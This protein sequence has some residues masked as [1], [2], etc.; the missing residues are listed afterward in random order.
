MRGQSGMLA[1]HRLLLLAACMWAA[2][3]VLAPHAQQLVLDEEFAQA[4]QTLAAPLRASLTPQ[5][6]VH[7]V[8]V[9]DPA[10]NAFV[11]SENIIFIHSGLVQ[12]A[13]N[14]AALQGVIAHEL[15]H[16]ASN[17]LLQQE[18]HA[19]Q[20]MLGALAGAALGIGA[21]AAGAPQ[22]ATALMVG[23][24]AGAIQTMLSHTRTQEAEADS[25]AIA[26]LHKAGLSAQGMVD[27]FTTL[28]T[29][30]Q[31][32]YDA[33]PPWLVTHPLPPERLS[34]LTRATQSESA[35]L[36]SGLAKAESSINFPRLQAKVMALTASPGAVLRKY[37]AFD[38]VSRYARALAYTRQGKLDFAESNLAPILKE[39]PTDPFYRELTGQIA[40]QRGDLP[41]AYA[42]YKAL[43]TEFPDHIMFRYQLAE[44][45]RNQD[46]FPDAIAHYQAVTRMWP[47][48]AEP[49]LGLGL[50]YG[51]MGRLAE[52]HL[53][54]AQGFLVA[55]N[56]E[57]AR[58]SLALAQQ[59]LRTTP[60]PDAEQW[61]T[62][63]QTRLDNL[64]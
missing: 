22:A 38:S 4:A 50:C 30:S 53:A 19:K 49:W 20:A 57:A 10:I 33:P 63:L 58:Q 8:L 9:N 6:R 35:Q 11:T 40:L 14:A 16:I 15:A 34:S 18:V 48:W 45:L 60:N 62:A 12:K 32:S 61:A 13:K 23:G 25:R 28:R 2:A 36:T 55:P 1:K 5:T 7:Y 24:Q 27:M 52:S 64:K 26:A 59:Y 43:A 42:I 3:P 54:R 21:A 47:E 41:A 29:E 31:L 17:H 37:N 56:P 44:I 51:K 46:G 39:N